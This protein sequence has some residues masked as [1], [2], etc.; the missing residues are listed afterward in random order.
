M[1]IQ[2]RW[3]YEQMLDLGHRLFTKVHKR[4]Y[5][6]HPNHEIH[7]LAREINDWLPQGIQS[8]IDGNYWPRHLRRYHFSDETVDQLHISDRILQHILLQQ[9][10]PTFKHVM[11]PNCLHLNGPTGVKL[12]TQRVR[13]ALQEDQPQFFIRADI[14]SYYRSILHHKLLQDI[15]QHYDDSML[16][17]IIT[18]PI[19]TPRGY[20]NPDNGV[21][22]RG[23]LSQFFSALYLKPLDDAFDSMNV[24]Y[25]RYQDDRAPRTSL[26]RN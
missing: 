17:H 18:N 10:K 9:L 2:K 23:P 5:S 22:L 21:A 3:D 15:K 19:E 25:V 7:F 12:A 1:N 26:K 6:A 8:I 14:K 4:K 20:K 16:E 24:F 13:R 11:N